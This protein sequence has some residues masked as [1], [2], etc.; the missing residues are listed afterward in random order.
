[1]KVIQINY[2]YFV[3]GGPE[4]YMFKLREGLM[5]RGCEC[6]PYSV[7][8][9][10]N[11][12]NEY[13]K[14]FASPISRPQEYLFKEYSWNARSVV[15]G[16]SRLFYSKEVE[17]G[18]STLLSATQPDV[19]IVHHYLKKLS[20]AV[21]VALKRHEI[22]IIA[23]LH[24]F[25]LICAEAHFQRAG[26][27]CFDCLRRG[28]AE[29]VKN[30]CVKRSRAV[31]LINYLAGRWHE[32]KGYFDLVDAFIVPRQIHEGQIRRGGMG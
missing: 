17:N 1:M 21:L 11:L 7:R 23:I 8:Q 5:R 26:R 29:A 19:A 10:Q 28:P 24:D 22:P 30:A 20:P 6:I 31:S 32:R 14:H 9:T 3:S 12:P 25:N 16:L 18:L 27:I 13:E 2:R 15:R 4:V